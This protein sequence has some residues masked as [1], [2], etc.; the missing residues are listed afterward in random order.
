MVDPVLQAC[1]RDAATEEQPTTDG[2]LSSS[3]Q[4]FEV[5]KNQ[6]ERIN[7]PPVKLGMA[8]PISLGQPTKAELAL[9]ERLLEEMGTVA[10]LENE[11]GMRFRASVLAELQRI[12]S[13]WIYEVGLQQG[14]EAEYAK[15]A[16]GK[17][18]TFGSYRLGL[19]SA[20]SDIDALC[21]TPRHVSR[22]A[23]FQDLVPKLQEHPDVTELTPV[24]DAYVPIIKMKLCGIDI[25]LL[26]SRLSLTQISD[27]LE[28]LN[29]DNLLKNLDDKT[30][31][32]LNGCRVADHILSLV[33]NPDTFRATLRFVKLWAKRRGIYSNV[34]GFFGGITWAILVA[35]VCQLYPYYC[36][37]ALVNRF[38][39]VY[40]RWFWKNPVLLCPIRESSAPGLGAFKVWNPKVH[41]QD[42]MHLMPIITP[43]FP[44][45]NSTHNVSETTK[46]IIVE[47][48]ERGFK[49]VDQVQQGK[50]DWKDV[51][52]TLPF[53]SEYRMYL[54]I[55]IVARNAKVFA[56]WL[57]WVESKLRHLVK[58]LEQ[59]QGVQVR[60]WPQNIPYKDPE[61]PHATA[62]F[63]GLRLPRRGVHGQR[64]HT[65]NLRELVRRFV[66]LISR[67]NGRLENTSVCNMRIRDVKRR[68]LPDFV[69]DE[70]GTRSMRRNSTGEGPPSAESVVQPV[71]SLPANVPS[72]A[73]GPVVTASSPTAQL[74]GEPSA[75]RP[76]TTLID[77]PVQA[78][79]LPERA[80]QQLRPQQPE[81][82]QQQ[83]ARTQPM[84]R[85][86][87]E[88][89]STEDYQ[90]NGGVGLGG[91]GVKRSVPLARKK[92]KISVKLA[93]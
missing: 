75:K 15:N 87:Q 46:R 48:F 49:M 78:L 1:G 79:P 38:F 36:P 43:A 22:D 53:F 19:V 47:E 85:A 9:N 69:P 24:V 72:G 5:E 45:M 59:V 58:H 42:R 2:N 93:T 66:E 80:P 23:F 56:R 74:Q 82:E 33:P 60:P 6:E 25:D 10:P 12:V 29:D 68:E 76:R 37:A 92:G 83:P 21:V 27:E 35:R 57:G 55:E 86:Q 26:F 44:S 41:P 65:V 16:G 50:S 13:K 7:G 70:N 28:S 4:T 18:F 54:H 14:M 62:V 88:A 61:F 32:S 39:R 40:D 3:Q 91:F 71:L 67:W 52:K 11:E 63:M 84:L 8:D 20:G 30:V 77:A 90:V 89:P 51:A 17:L 73:V 64:G 31:R 34:L 81:Q